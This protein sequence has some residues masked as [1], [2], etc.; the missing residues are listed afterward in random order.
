MAD[1]AAVNSVG[2][3]TVHS[4]PV[5]SEGP[6]VSS[7]AGPQM[8]RGSAV[9]YAGQIASAAAFVKGKQLVSQVRDVKGLQDLVANSGAQAREIM[10]QYQGQKDVKPL[11]EELS[12]KLKETESQ[13]Q[14][15]GD[16]GFFAKASRYIPFMGTRFAPLSSQ[17][18]LQKTLSLT[19]DQFMIG[20]DQH[21]KLRKSLA[22]MRAAMH[23]L[24]GRRVGFAHDYN[25]TCEQHEQVKQQIE[26]LRAQIADVPETS[27]EGAELRQQLNDAETELLDIGRQA[28][29]FDFA[30][31]SMDRALQMD[32]ELSETIRNYL[33]NMEEQLGTSQIEIQKLEHN[34]STV[35]TS[36]DAAIAMDNL[37]VATST[38]NTVI[39]SAIRSIAKA[40]LDADTKLEELKKKLAES[41]NAT[42][43]MLKTVNAVQEA[44]DKEFIEGT[45]AAGPMAPAGDGTYQLP[46]LEG[47]ASAQSFQITKKIED[48]MK[49]VVKK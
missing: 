20:A 23:E 15:V 10:K 49:Q 27:T 35:A 25:L 30:I 33:T 47:G 46:K 6:A 2:A 17:E 43:A 3:S 9:A 21:D 4:G 34:L 41:D 26:E 12:K 44:K 22:D 38:C 36:V 28:R 48:R 18:V 32:A 13:M 37:N 7:N 40:Q 14:K 11:M 42:T 8:Q 16:P 39:N 31:K 24:H 5:A 29:F 1:T 19:T 45:L